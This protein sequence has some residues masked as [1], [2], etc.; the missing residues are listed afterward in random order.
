MAT[1][2][3]VLRVLDK[4][5]TVTHIADG[6]ETTSVGRFTAAHESMDQVA[7]KYRGSTSVVM[8]E[9]EDIVTISYID[10]KARPVKPR[11][12]GLV[13]EKNVRQHLAFNH[14]FTLTQVNSLSVN[15]AFAIH[16]GV[17]HAD[18]GHVHEDMSGQFVRKGVKL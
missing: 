6:E 5:V 14:G 17:D 2:G 10:P 9:L 1:A 11:R 15:E 16:D 13:N 12:L 18:L 8:L 3:E 4:Q 7:F